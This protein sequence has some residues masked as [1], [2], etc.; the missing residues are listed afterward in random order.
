MNDESN[1]PDTPE[2]ALQRASDILGGRAELARLFGISRR[3]AAYWTRC[4]AERVIPV[5]RATQGQVTRH[6]L[7]PD[8]YPLEDEHRPVSL[9]H[10]PASLGDNP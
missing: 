2:A 9:P 10:Q 7:R 4:P 3:A 6:Q 1:I 5:E 8:L